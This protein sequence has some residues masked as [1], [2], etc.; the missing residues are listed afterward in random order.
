MKIT[1]ALALHG[2]AG[3]E[4]AANT[5]EG[6]IEF[7]AV[8]EHGRDLGLKILASGG[9]AMDA[10]E[11]VV[12]YLEDDPHY[13]A[14]RGAVMN[15]A[16][17]IELDA[18]I[19]DGKTGQAGAVAGMRTVK[20]PVTLARLVM[21]ETKH[22]LLIGDG[23]EKFAD[24]MKGKP[25]IE[26]V[27]NSYFY[28]EVRRQQLLKAQE[29]EK[30]EKNNTPPAHGTV[31]CVALDSH[32]NLAAATSTG[33]TNNKRFGR[34]GDTPIIGAGNY[35]NN[36][37]C[38][39]SGTGT[40]EYFIRSSAAFHIHALMAYKGMSVEEALA[41]VVNNVLPKETGGLIVVDRDGRI[42]MLTNTGGL[43]RAAG[44]S[45]GYKM[46]KLEK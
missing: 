32:G 21:T 1:Y 17:T 16:G 10:V 40:G 29:K 2:G 44:D 9:T 19:M 5:P 25:G 31:G 3:V 18:S 36:L 35:A 23:A 46:V 27:E 22:V 38:A 34:V 12:R 14:G 43:S 11:Q 13:N 30:A 7:E 8:L 28:T 39:V 15:S 33:G 41:E 20:N 37:T 42:A 4:P 26:R 6:K 24:E 45:S